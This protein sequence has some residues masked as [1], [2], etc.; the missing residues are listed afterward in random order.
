MISRFVT[1]LLSITFF[2]ISKEVLPSLCHIF[3]SHM[4]AQLCRL[5]MKL[6]GAALTS[7]S[8]LVL[9]HA[10]HVGMEPSATSIYTLQIRC[11]LCKRT[12]YMFA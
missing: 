2:V 1:L 7:F 11:L 12:M 8:L 6:P 3:C 10:H 5:K 9:I 4:L